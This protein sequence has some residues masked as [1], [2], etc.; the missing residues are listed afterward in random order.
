MCT[1]LL[2]RQYWYLVRCTAV[3]GVMVV[4]LLPSTH[5]VTGQACLDVW[6]IGKFTVIIFGSIVNICL[7]RALQLQFGYHKK[8]WYLHSYMYA[9]DT[10]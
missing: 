1:Y 5:P 8:T 4:R 3:H 6:N 10:L 7:Q 9:M 2:V